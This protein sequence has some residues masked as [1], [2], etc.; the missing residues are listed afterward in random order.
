M[1]SLISDFN[2]VWIIHEYKNATG[3][4]GKMIWFSKEDILTMLCHL[5]GN[6]RNGVRIYR[7]KYPD[8][9]NFSNVGGY[10]YRNKKTIVFMPT[11]L[12]DGGEQEDEIPKAKVIQIVKDI[13]S[14]NIPRELGFNHGELCPPNCG[15][16]TIEDNTF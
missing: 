6:N 2:S 16:D 12:N 14:G 10:N 1:A 3:D 4:Q 11:F 5:H 13:K 15:G 8:H 9:E 7:G